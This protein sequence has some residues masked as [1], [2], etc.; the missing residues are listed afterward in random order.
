MAF[1]SMLDPVEV[2]RAGG[3]LDAAWSRLQEERSENAASCSEREHIRLA[4]IISSLAKVALD[5][6]ELEER[7]LKQFARDA[8]T[9]NAAAQ[10]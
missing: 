5:E 7:A 10:P 6:D 3:A 9:E 1:S 4:E 8:L 2:A